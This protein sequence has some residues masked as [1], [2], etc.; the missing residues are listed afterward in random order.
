LLGKGNKIVFV[1][2]LMN[3]YSWRVGTG[4][5]VGKRDKGEN[6]GRDS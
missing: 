3:G 1:F 6:T 4:G 5:R 2:F